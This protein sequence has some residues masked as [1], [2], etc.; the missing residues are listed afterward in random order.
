MSEDLNIMNDIHTK[1]K[2]AKILNPI[3]TCLHIEPFQENYVDISDLQELVIC[4][5]CWKLLIEFLK[6]FHDT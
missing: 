2:P 1:S 5:T 6:S 3:Q 4:D